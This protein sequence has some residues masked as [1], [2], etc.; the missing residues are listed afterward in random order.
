MEFVNADRSHDSAFL[1]GLQ[2]YNNRV[3]EDNKAIKIGLKSN[4]DIA[5]QQQELIAGDQS[6]AQTKTLLALSGVGTGLV[7]K[8]ARFPIVQAKAAARKLAA[9]KAANKAGARGVGA[10]IRGPR[11]PPSLSTADALGRRGPQP[12]PRR[13]PSL[14][15]AGGPRPPPS[16]TKAEVLAREGGARPPPSLTK[17]EVLAREGGLAGEEGAEVGG[18]LA[19]K[20]SLKVAEASTGKLVV[21]GLGIAAKGAGLVGAGISAADAINDYRHGK[22]GW[23]QGLELGGAAAEVFGTILDFTPLA[24]LGVGLQIAGAAASAAGTGLAAVEQGDETSKAQEDTIEENKTADA[25]LNAQKRRAVSGLTS[26]SQGGAA[27]ARQVQ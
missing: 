4:K 26:A 7:E 16:L 10:A 11:P 23:A 14:S 1:A 12:P 2:N 25:Q 19:A 15:K 22:F 20:E 9:E 6:E 5:K 17:A 13:L 21:K 18:S 8:K 24:P 27:V 3:F